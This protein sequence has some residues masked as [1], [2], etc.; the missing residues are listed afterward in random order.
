MTWDSVCIFS[1]LLITHTLEF[2][3]LL[4][5]DPDL[6]PLWA[7][8]EG[9]SEDPEVLPASFS[10]PVDGIRKTDLL[11]HTCRNARL[12]GEEVVEE[13]MPPWFSAFYYFIFYS[14]LSKNNSLLAW[15][16]PSD[17]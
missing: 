10:E 13:N 14:E 3:F 2:F 8:A 15:I 12:S 5:F 1:V 7:F 17:C 9:G 6:S 16:M 11:S 4:D